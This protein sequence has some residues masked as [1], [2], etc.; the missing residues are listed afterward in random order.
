VAYDKVR[1]TPVIVG[2]K[3]IVGT[4]GSILA[5]GGGVGGKLIAFNKNTGAVMWMTTLDAHPAAII[6][7]SATVH[8]NRVYVGV[9]S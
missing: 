7:Q 6:T 2:D 5:P 9:A 3:L 1:A 4:Q 8:G